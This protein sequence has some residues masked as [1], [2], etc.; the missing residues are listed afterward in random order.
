MDPASRPCIVLLLEM[1]TAANP[2]STRATALLEQAHGIE[3]DVLSGL[4]RPRDREWITKERSSHWLNMLF[5]SRLYFDSSMKGLFCMDSSSIVALFKAV[6]SGMVPNRDAP[7]AIVPPKRLAIFLYVCA[8][9]PSP[10]R[11][12]GSSWGS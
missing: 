10:R 2:A 9:G 11:H 6:F 1:V 5:S 7:D 12:P 8:H 4:F 3:M